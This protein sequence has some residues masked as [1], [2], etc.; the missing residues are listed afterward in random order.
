ML[1]TYFMPAKSAA[2]PCSKATGTM[3]ANSL[4]N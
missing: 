1:K 4:M 2:Y 3:V